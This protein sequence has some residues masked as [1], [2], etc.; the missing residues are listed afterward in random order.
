MSD[1]ARI[2]FLLLST[3]AVPSYWQVFTIKQIRLMSTLYTVKQYKVVNLGLNV[4]RPCNIFR[5]LQTAKQSLQ[6]LKC[7]N[8]TIKTNCSEVKIRD[9]STNTFLHFMNNGIACFHLVIIWKSLFLE[10]CIPSSLS[11]IISYLYEHNQK[12]AFSEC[13]VYYRVLR[14]R[15]DHG[16][17]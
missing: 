8:N 16:K 17:R 2:Y 9:T 15:L 11:F 6:A 10:V 13:Y 4:M 12:N 1:W 3:A 14:Y 7:I 5:V